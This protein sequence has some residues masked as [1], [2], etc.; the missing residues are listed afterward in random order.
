[1]A[2]QP[3]AIRLNAHELPSGHLIVALNGHLTAVIDGVIHDLFDA[4]C[5]GT[6]WVLG[7]FYQP[8]A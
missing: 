2:T 5:G 3:G 8:A 1:M 4:S 7:Y 6:S